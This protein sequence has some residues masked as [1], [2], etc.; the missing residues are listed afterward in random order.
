MDTVFVNFYM[1]AMSFYTT[2]EFKL[3]ILLDKYKPLFRILLRH[4]QS[5]TLVL[6]RFVII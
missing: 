2:I 3:R 1:Y 5:I 6:C 4:I